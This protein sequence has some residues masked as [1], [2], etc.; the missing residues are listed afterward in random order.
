[1]AARLGIATNLHA[2]RHYSATE[3]IAAGVDVRTVAGRLGHGGGGATTLRVYAAWL[4]ESDQRAAASLAA[5]IPGPPR[6]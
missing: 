5:R 2:L 4:S 3:L 1:M 6:S